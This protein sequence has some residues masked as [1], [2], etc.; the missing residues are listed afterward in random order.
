M[1]TRKHTAWKKNRRFGD[2]KGGRLRVKCK[3]GIFNR[4]HS[5]LK[6]SKGVETPVFMVENPSKDFYFPI[7]PDDIKEVLKKLPNEHTRSLSYI[8]LRKIKKRDYLNDPLQ[9]S[10]IVGSGVHLIILY[11]FPIDNRMIFGKVKP[12]QKKVNYYKNYTTELQQDDKG[13]WYLQWAEDEIKKYYLENLLLYEI[14]NSIHSYYSIYWSKA[15][16][17]KKEAFA[18]SYAAFWGSAIK[19]DYREISEID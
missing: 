7:T 1:Q 14:G 15:A 18:D 12:L 5:F 10:F 19:N 8:W 16:D 13:Y 2:I 6:P 4:Y 3:D 17:K 9:G 11:P